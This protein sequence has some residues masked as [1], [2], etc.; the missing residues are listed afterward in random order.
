MSRAAWRRLLA[1][2]ALA[3]LLAALGWLLHAGGYVTRPALIGLA[4]R[5]AAWAP[6]LIVVAMVGAVVIGPIPTVPISVASGVVFGPVL[7]FAYASAGALAGALL[8]F[9]LARRLGRPFV[10]RLARGHIEVCPQCSDRLLFWVVLASRLVPIVSFALVSYGAGLTAMTARAFALA[11][12]V[13]MTPMT[14]VYVSVGASVTI[15]PVWAAIGGALAVAA[16]LALP[17]LVERRDPFGM[18]RLLPRH[19]PTGSE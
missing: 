1:I 7:G 2:A 10:A 3:A 9:G 15:D 8:A 19:D 17:R 18:R 12:L 4:E 16:A 13:G 11:T 14:V 6:V 5:H